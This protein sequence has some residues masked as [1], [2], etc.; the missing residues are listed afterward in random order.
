MNFMLARP[1]NYYMIGGSG[2]VIPPKV[3]SVYDGLAARAALAGVT[4]KAS[5]TNDV[6]SALETLQVRYN[7]VSFKQSE[8]D[9]GLMVVTILCANVYPRRC[10]G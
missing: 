1:A 4:I 9:V 7:A 2:R 8:C 6:A 3:T 5:L 10:F